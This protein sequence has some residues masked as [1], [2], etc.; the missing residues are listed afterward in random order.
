MRSIFC[1]LSD[2]AVCC[3]VGKEGEGR[4]RRFTDEIKACPRSSAMILEGKKYYSIVEGLHEVTGQK[5]H[6]YAFLD[7][8][9]KWA[10]GYFVMSHRNS[11]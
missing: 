8:M 7:A 4:G 9:E 3:A 10:T 6:A 2:H 5:E 1:P 11:L